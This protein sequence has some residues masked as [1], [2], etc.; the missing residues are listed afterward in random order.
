M[1]QEGV[2]FKNYSKLN[3]LKKCDVGYYDYVDIG[4]A[5]DETKRHSQLND[6]IRS[7][8]CEK[9]ITEKEAKIK[10]ASKDMLS[11]HYYDDTRDGCSLCPN[12][13]K[14]RRIQWFADFPEAMQL[15][16]D[17][18]EIVKKERPERYPLRGNKYFID[19]DQVDLFGNFTIN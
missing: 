7:I 8:L 14:N 17:L 15:V 16:I 11:P 1:L 3:A 6:K 10:V 12:A 18:Q 19:T 4:I 13:P 2:H 9:K 5:Y